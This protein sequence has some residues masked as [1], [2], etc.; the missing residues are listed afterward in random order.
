MPALS[1][2]KEYI[3]E[4]MLPNLWC[5][6]CGNGV[7]AG[8]IARAIASLDIP[9]NKVVM[10]TGI[11]CSGKTDD[12]FKT[13][14]L[15]GTHGRALAFATGIKASRPEL[16]VIVPMGDG[17]GATIGGN[18]LIHA[19]RRNI[20]LTALVYNNKN[21]GMTG[22]QVSATTPQNAFTSTTVFG[23]PERDFDLCKLV[24]VAG[25]AYVARGT[26]Y[27][28]QQLHQLIRAGL[29]K[30]GFSFIEVMST[31]P[32]HYGRRNNLGSAVEM[33]RSLKEHAVNV[34]SWEKMKGDLPKD[35]FLIGRLSERDDPDFS[36]SYEQVRRKALAGQK[37]T[38]TRRVKA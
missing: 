16:T 24:E 31:C 5:P 12:Y 8:A 17:D 9:R 1:N 21:Y 23:N 22:G 18:H 4:S 27:H 14:A 35:F 2:W 25:A 30:K 37:A 38:K 33:M 19:A 6:G 13:N 3:E 26:V 29:A 10:V 32:I 15:H 28:A 34:K 20:D 11:G 36:T 7:I